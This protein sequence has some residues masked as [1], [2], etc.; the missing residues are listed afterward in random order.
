MTRSPS[1]DGPDWSPAVKHAD[2]SRE[3]QVAEAVALVRGLL[4]DRDASKVSVRV[5]RGGTYMIDAEV[6]EGKV[7]GVVPLSR[8]QR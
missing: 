5:A 2:L 7:A 3:E 8:R 4:G 1:S 6:G